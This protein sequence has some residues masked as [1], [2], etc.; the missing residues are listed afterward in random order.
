MN[1]TTDISPI[2]EIVDD[3]K[4]GKM[5]ILV[6]EEDRENEGDLVMAAEHVTPEAVNFMAQYG[7]GLICLT[8]TE[9][10]CRQLRL[11]PMVGS[12]GSRMGTNFTASIEAAEGVTTGISAADRAKTI[13]VAS[14]PDASFD[15]LVQPGHVFPLKAEE[16]GVLVRAGHTEAGCDLAL[17][18]G[19]QPTSV[20]CEILKENGEMARLPDLVKFSR[21]HGLK[22]GTIAD[23]IA[24]RGQN[25]SLVERVLERPIDTVAGSFDLVAYRDRIS[26][27]VHLALVK[28]KFAED[29][30]VLVRVHE[31]FS[32]ADL[33]DKNSGMHSWRF[34]DALTTINEIGKGV[35]ILIHRT[36]DGDALLQ[37]LQPKQESAPRVDLRNY[38]IGAQILKDLGV[39]RMRLMATPRRMPSMTGFDLEII[40]YQE[41]TSE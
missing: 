31:P 8:L 27:E 34:D 10:K 9:D 35:L 17:M 32:I 26:K 22:I 2:P 11:T 1:M 15:D 29:D 36:E 28:G 3:L 33:L 18:A 30:E 24:Y 20:I 6:D 12:N 14:S 37:H 39:S 5:V 38:G 16:G 7:R 41:K 40:G 25:E 4:Q 13:K 21:Q 23:L 19:L